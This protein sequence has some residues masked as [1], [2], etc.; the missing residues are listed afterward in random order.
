MGTELQSAE[1]RLRVALADP[2]DDRYNV[3]RE[4]A[5]VEWLRSPSFCVSPSVA[6]YEEY[7]R[8]GVLPPWNP[9]RHKESK[10][11][12]QCE[13][14][15][16]YD[17]ATLKGYRE[18]PFSLGKNVLAG[19]VNAVVP[20]SDLGDAGSSGQLVGQFIGGAASLFVNPATLVKN[21]SMNLGGVLGNIL[22]TG[23]KF[24]SSPI[25][26][27]ATNFL[28][29]AVMP[30]RT[31]I[32]SA[33]LETQQMGTPQRSKET[34]RINDLDPMRYTPAQLA[35]FGELQLPGGKTVSVND[36]GKE[37]Y[38]SPW[39][40]GAGVVLFF[41]FGWLLLFKRKR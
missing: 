1:E 3:A 22:N 24:V 9:G 32:V 29:Q 27:V 34:L 39:A 37:W 7:K 5:S 17:L 6:D 36:T 41:L 14:A 16:Q 18:D 13:M 30:T 40:I 26:Q 21:A 31:T 28:S 35:A 11:P 25:G 19:V 12:A 33:P 8:T 2:T 23:S 10:N 38:K 15:F 20:G 4:R